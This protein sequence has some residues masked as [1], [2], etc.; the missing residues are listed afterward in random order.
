MHVNRQRVF[1]WIPLL[2]CTIIAL[3][4]LWLPSLTSVMADDDTPRAG[5]D[6]AEIYRRVSKSVVSIEVEIGRF[7]VASGTGFV[8]DE[9][10]HIV[11]NAHVVEDAFAIA[12]EF[13]DGLQTSAE[14]IGMDTLVDIAVIKVDVRSYR[15]KPVTFGDSDDLAVGQSVLAIGNPFGLEGTL[16][17]GI[18]SGLDRSISFGDGSTIEGAI[19]TDA[20]LGRG[21]SG[22]PLI[23]HAGEVIGVNTAGYTGLSGSSNFGFAIPS[24]LARRISENMIA[25]RTE[26]SYTGVAVAVSTPTIERVLDSTSI[27]STPRS[28]LEAS[29]ITPTPTATLVQPTVAVRSDLLRPVI[30]PPISQPTT[31]S[32]SGASVYQ[33]NVGLGQVFSIGNIQLQGGVRLFLQNPVDANSFLRTDYKGIL[34]YKPIGVAQEGEM[35]YS[36]YFEGYSGGIVNIDQNRNRIVELDWSADGRQFSFALILRLDWTIR[37]QAS[38]FGS[39]TW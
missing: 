22:G 37:M 2:V 10:G 16:T 14:L 23:N 21:N 29:T 4:Y 33:Y 19:Q 5:E 34:R 26:R 15:L 18:I 35:S 20:A 8:V 39:L 30:Q 27:V 12:V 6:I 3:A 7:D 13:Q 1:I 9:Y 38:G 28:Q 11:T 32:I 24:N 17:T 31:F 36:P 25:Q